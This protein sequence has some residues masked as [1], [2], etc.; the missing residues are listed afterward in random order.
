M[1]VGALHVV[2]LEDPRWKPDLVFLEHVFGY[3]GATR[4]WSVTGYRKAT[5]WDRPE[6]GVTHQFFEKRDVSVSTAFRLWRKQRPRVCAWWIGC[7]EWSDRLRGE[8]EGTGEAVRG[9]FSPR[10][11]NVT[12][13]PVSLPTWERDATLGVFD[14]SLTMTDTH[15][16]N[17]PRQ[18]L[19][20]ASQTPTLKALLGFLGDHSGRV[21]SLVVSHVHGDGI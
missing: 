20:L 19:W 10:D 2:S 5:E 9:R 12:W 13:G 4:V 16:P 18:Y 15:V 6:A 14:F 17:D 8:L 3:L 7:N 11:M 21:F 1:D